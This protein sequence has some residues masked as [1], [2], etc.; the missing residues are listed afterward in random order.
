MSYCER[1][2]H[3]ALELYPSQAEMSYVVLTKKEMSGISGKTK[4]FQA[5]ECK[6][7]SHGILYKDIE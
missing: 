1:T 2:I 5:S 7:S 6:C 4:I 3:L